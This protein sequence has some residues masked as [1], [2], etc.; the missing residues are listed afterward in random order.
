VR[1]DQQMPPTRPLTCLW[2]SEPRGPPFG[3][4]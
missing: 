1:V 3:S 4:S 2:A